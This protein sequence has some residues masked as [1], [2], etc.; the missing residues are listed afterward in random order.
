MTLPE[1]PKEQMNSNNYYICL[2]MNEKGTDF[3]EIFKTKD[4]N[5]A[6]KW[7]DIKPHLRTYHEKIKE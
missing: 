7:V 5:E 4:K 2:E 3:F 6:Q 1:M